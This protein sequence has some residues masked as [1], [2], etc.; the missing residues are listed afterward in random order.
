MLR[1]MAEVVGGSC[2]SRGGD[3][4]C[5]AGAGQPSRSLRTREKRVPSP[6]RAG[7]LGRLQ[8]CGGSMLNEWSFNGPAEVFFGLL[9]R[10]CRPTRAKKRILARTAAAYRPPAALPPALPAPF[11]TL[12]CASAR[13]SQ[14]RLSRPAPH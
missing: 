4:A 6:E 11:A 1:T 13:K 8:R 2:G 9:P 5:W 14:G 12:A 3:M 7:V 10:F